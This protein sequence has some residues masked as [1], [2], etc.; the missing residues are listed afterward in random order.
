MK[1]E[2]LAANIVLI[3]LLAGCR[4]VAPQF[5]PPT[6]VSQ[7]CSVTIEARSHRFI[8]VN[9]KGLQTIRTVGS[10]EDAI[11]LRRAGDGL[12]TLGARAASS[13][14]Y[15]VTYPLEWGVP[16]TIWS[17]VKQPKGPWKATVPAGSYQSMIRYIS[18]ENDRVVCEAVSAAVELPEFLILTAE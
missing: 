3:T 2:S 6:D 15:G 18:P 5:A 13:W 11:Q 10:L 16:Q 1:R 9:P 17:S 14:T 8:F 4:A 7:L 12:A